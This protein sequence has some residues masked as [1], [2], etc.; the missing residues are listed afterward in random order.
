MRGNNGLVGVGPA[1]QGRHGGGR[2]S[3]RQT[4]VCPSSVA[5]LTA[6]RFR[7]PKDW[8]WAEVRAAAAASWAGTPLL[9]KDGRP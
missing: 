3:D 9:R 2:R 6:E 7:F 1:A 5:T 8:A 4:I